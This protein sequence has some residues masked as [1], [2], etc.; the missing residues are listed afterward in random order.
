MFVDLQYWLPSKHVNHV[1][2]RIGQVGT[3]S[4]TVLTLNREKHHTKQGEKW[5]QS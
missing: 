5:H 4:W 1:T 2:I 3:T